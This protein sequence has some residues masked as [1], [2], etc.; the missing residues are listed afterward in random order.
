MTYAAVSVLVRT[1]DAACTLLEGGQEQEKAHSG[2]FLVGRNADGAA[3]EGKKRADRP[4][5]CPPQPICN[6]RPPEHVSMPLWAFYRSFSIVRTRYTVDRAGRSCSIDRPSYRP[7]C[8]LFFFSWQ[9]RGPIGAHL[10]PKRQV[11]TAQAGSPR[12][13]A[14]KYGKTGRQMGP[15]KPGIGAATPAAPVFYG[16]QQGKGK[17]K[18]REVCPKHTAELAWVHAEGDARMAGCGLREWAFRWPDIT[19]CA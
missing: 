16:A 5:Q 3:S 9:P 12:I 7:F 18:G 8:M 6:D 14:A 4:V 13:S 1:L 10:R 15:C 19:G 11:P 17:K 2:T